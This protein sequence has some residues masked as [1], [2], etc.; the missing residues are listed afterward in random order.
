MIIN[1]QHRKAKLDERLRSKHLDEMFFS[2]IHKGTN[3]STFESRAI[4][5]QARRIYNLGDPNPDSG[6]RSGQLKVIGIDAQEPAGKALGECLKKEAIVTW[7]AGEEDHQVRFGPYGSDEKGVAALRRLRLARITQEAYDQGVLLSQEDLAYRYLNCGLRTIRRD[8]S[9]FKAEG[10]WI[11]T[12]GQQKDIGRGTSHRVEAVRRH[13]AGKPLTQIAREMYH[14]VA[15]VERYVHTFSRVTYCTQQGF[16][17]QETAFALRI[18]QALVREYIALLDQL[19][20]SPQKDRVEE[21][22]DLA[23]PLFP[24]KREKGGELR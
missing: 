7:D 10:I 24:P 22:V 17:P 19:K 21:L 5:E 9:L 18:S 12:R 3:C 23:T 6:P 1:A 8:V 14:S 4:V 16:S 13:V 15:A 20:D 11:P 2:L